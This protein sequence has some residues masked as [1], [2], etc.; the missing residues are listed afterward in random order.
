[1]PEADRLFIVVLVLILLGMAFAGPFL[2][3]AGAVGGIVGDPL[4]TPPADES[5]RMLEGLGGIDGSG[6]AD[7]RVDRLLGQLRPAVALREWKGILILKLDEETQPEKLVASYAGKPG[8]HEGA[9]FH[10]VVGRRI[11]VLPTAR[12]RRQIPWT[13]EGAENPDDWII[14]VVLGDAAGQGRAGLVVRALKREAAPGARVA[15]KQGHDG[16]I[17][18]IEEGSK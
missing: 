16:P 3:P 15:M 4:L 1:M 13:V 14:I 2:F 11:Q 9:P 17:V 10:L 18:T 7:P 12:W 8:Y 5:Y 6:G